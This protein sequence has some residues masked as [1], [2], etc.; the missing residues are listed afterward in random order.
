MFDNLLDDQSWRFKP[1]GEPGDWERCTCA[2]HS[3][4]GRMIHVMACCHGGWKKTFQL[5]GKEM[6]AS[7]AARR[8]REQKAKTYR[9]VHGGYP[10]A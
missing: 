10:S 7:Q 3:S 4:M 9:P 1:K 2:C 6:L 8:A 5:I